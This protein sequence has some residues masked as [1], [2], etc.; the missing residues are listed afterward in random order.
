MEE[1][2]TDYEVCVVRNVKPKSSPIGLIDRILK[3]FT[4]NIF[5]D[6]MKT[7]ECIV[8]RTKKSE[9]EIKEYY[10]EE[11]YE[12]T[13]ISECTRTKNQELEII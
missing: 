4:V 7:E 5:Q 10:R 1:E 9:E 11:G 2:Y 8:I 12:V 6:T 3:G 13:G